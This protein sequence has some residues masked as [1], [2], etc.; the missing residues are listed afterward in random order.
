MLMNHGESLVATIAGMKSAISVS[1]LTKKYGDRYAV[2]S[3]TFD[4]PAGSI[5]GFI[6]PNGSGKTTTMRALLGLI[7]P[8]SGTGKILGSDISQPNEYLQKVGAIIETPSFYPLLSGIG[9][10]EVLAD[11]GG[12]PRK[13]ARELIEL[14]G[15]GDRASSKFKTYSLGMKQR[16]GIAAALL[17]NPDLL[18]LDEPTNGLDPSG[19]L[20]IRNLIKKLATGGKTVFIS[21][22]LLSELEAICDYLV[23]I[24]S[25]SIIYSGTANN[26]V[27]SSE[28][29]VLIIEPEYSVDLNKL[30]KI[31]DGEGFEYQAN[32]S[33]LEVKATNA[34]AAHLN[35][36]AFTEGVTL[37]TISE[38]KSSLE[39]TFFEKVAND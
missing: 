5:C 6:G 16:L 17:P 23:L 12:I 8:N 39:A 15:L 31:L 30:V 4:V 34:A 25:G 22:H 14:V 32:G 35:R 28:G 19:I 2:D 10:L 26:F 18:I 9:N 3:A 33:T 37:K 36:L 13:R 29:K 38:H 1:G 24:K 11:L 21:S 20:E 7:K 27:D